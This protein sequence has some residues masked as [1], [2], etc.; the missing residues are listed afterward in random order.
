MLTSES[1]KQTYIVSSYQAM[2]F[3]NVFGTFPTTMGRFSLLMLYNRIFQSDRSFYVAVRIVGIL[4]SLIY[5]GCTVAIG[6]RCA[7]TGKMWNPVAQGQCFHSSKALVVALAFLD[8]LLD[9]M[10]MIL[11]ISVLRRLQMSWRRKIN[12]AMIFAI[13]GL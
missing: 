9:F 8:S 3:S 12:V 10:V 1:L 5:V 6:F 11:P 13:G 2:Y 7:P 4:N